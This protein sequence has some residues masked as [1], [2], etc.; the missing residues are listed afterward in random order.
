MTFLVTTEIEEHV[1]W[2][3][4]SSVQIGLNRN[5]ME[6]LKTEVIYGK[7][8]ERNEFNQQN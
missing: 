7:R 2:M 4:H 6:N 1:K 8:K 3:S 5:L